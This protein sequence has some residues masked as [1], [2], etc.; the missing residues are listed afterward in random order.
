MQY[1]QGR[2]ISTFWRSE[3]EG[4]KA[5]L[6]L[7]MQNDFIDMR[8]RNPITQNHASQ[9]LSNIN[10]LIRHA[11]AAGWTVSYVGNGY[12]SH[13]PLNLFRNFAAIVDTNGGKLH[14]DLLVVNKEYF[15]KRRANA[16][17]NKEL[18]K[19]MKLQNVETLYITGVRAEACVLG[20]T[21]GSIKE[22]MHPIVVTDA[23]GANSEKWRQ[24]ML[25]KYAR[26]GA[27]LSLTEEVLAIKN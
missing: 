14:P 27:G 9:I 2:V 7:D 15:W 21:K 19:A 24:F 8:G 3:A 13:D 6:V 22:G 25:A 26:I 5:L 10:L 18:A 12:R 23:I 20:T 11:Q 16:F 4:C 17:T 1:V